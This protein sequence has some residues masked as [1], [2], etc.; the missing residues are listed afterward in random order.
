MQT[1]HRI[2]SK[3][4]GLESARYPI[5]ALYVDEPGFVKGD[6]HIDELIEVLHGWGLLSEEFYVLKMGTL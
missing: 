5:E 3:L 6:R 1:V 4:R 2:T